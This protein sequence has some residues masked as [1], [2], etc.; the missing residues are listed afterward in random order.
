[1]SCQAVKNFFKERSRVRNVVV[2][3]PAKG[4]GG[5]EWTRLTVCGE[6]YKQSIYDVI[7]DVAGLE[8]QNARG[9]LTEYVKARKVVFHTLTDEQLAECETLATRWNRMGLPLALKKKCD[10]SRDA[11]L[12]YN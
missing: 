1:M 9:W 7:K 5:R 2:S 11:I 6:V 10:D 12:F 4:R 3:L 8:S